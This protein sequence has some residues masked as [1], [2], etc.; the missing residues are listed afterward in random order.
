VSE[1]VRGKVVFTNPG[2]K[3]ITLKEQ[4]SGK[5]IKTIQVEVTSLI[6]DKAGAKITDIRVAPLK[7]K[8]GERIDYSCTT[9]TEVIWDFNGEFKSE[10]KQGTATFTQPG[11][12]TIALKEKLTGKTVK[13][14]TIE[15]TRSEVQTVTEDENPITNISISRSG[16]M[17]EM[18][19]P[20]PASP[21]RRLSGILTVSLV[22]Q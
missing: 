12:K 17:S 14:V 7:I 1:T 10:L 11:I 6:P 22:L 19:Y 20:F 5:I 13:T 4:G 21:K 9:G 18:R 16:L 2:S 8:T 3:M 15:V